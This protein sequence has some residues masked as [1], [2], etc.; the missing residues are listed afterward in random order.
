MIS[1][2]EGIL[3][4]MLTGLIVGLGAYLAIRDKV[5][6]LS[7]RFDETSRRLESVEKAVGVGSGDG[8]GQFVTRREFD[9]LEVE[10][11]RRLGG[12]ET[13]LRELRAEVVESKP[14]PNGG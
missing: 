5:N 9:R 1:F 7:L 14:K 11:D 10:L 6:T 8:S 2:P 12:I 3:G 13:E 4:P